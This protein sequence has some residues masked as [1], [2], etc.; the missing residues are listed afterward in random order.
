M[1]DLQE[2]R[3]FMAGL[4][5]SATLAISGRA[6][7]MRA[8]GLDVCSM[9]AGEPDFD[10]PKAIKDACIAALNAGKVGYTAASGM[11][12]LKKLIAEKFTAED[13]IPTTPDRVV[14][15]PGAK[16]SIFS[17]IGALCGPGDEV[18]I[19]APFW[20][21]YPE[22]VR[23]S[24][25]IPVALPTSAAAAY[26]PD[27]AA[28]D[29]AIT[30]RTRLIILNSPSNPTGAVYRRETLEAI[31][32]VAVRRNVMVLADEIYG[33][34]TYNPAL[35]H[36][37][38]ASL[39]SEIADRTITVNG[40]SKT[41]AMTGWRLG[42]LTAP[43]WLAKRIAALQSH[44]TSNPTTFAQYGAVAALEGKAEDEVRAMIRAFG[45][46]RELICGLLEKIPHL[47]F[48]KPDGAFYV[49]C[50]ISSFGLNS[51]DFCARLLEKA[52]VAAIP[53]RSFNAE[54]MI[55]LSYACSEDNIRK[56]VER[57]GNFCAGLGSKQGC[58]K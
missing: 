33:R 41:Y 53:G 27:A 5:P 35:P 12:E 52:L 56:S 23:A 19:P 18:I 8:S 51:D 37:S 34:L 3:G 30:D 46:R 24:G 43:L 47:T 2:T 16:F 10:T 54:G 11:P 6:K 21:S 9:S 26:E 38:I 15:A 48:H 20:L 14:V 17:A 55:R 4:R 42:Y 31:A 32:E 7:E 39:N 22:I 44:A 40:F 29:A 36:C 28:L 45:E 49:M 57:I 58:A 25:A 1:L 50:D 13:G